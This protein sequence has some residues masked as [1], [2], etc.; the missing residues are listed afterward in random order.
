MNTATI[1]VSPIG[2]V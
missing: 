1:A 2:C